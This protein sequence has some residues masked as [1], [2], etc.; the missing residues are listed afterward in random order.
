MHVNVQPG[1]VGMLLTTALAFMALLYA[2][3]APDVMKDEGQ[4]WTKPSFAYHE[5]AGPHA[6]DTHDA[7]DT[8]GEEH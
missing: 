3:V 4:N 2:G 8:H 5:T 7:S 6:S 1:Y